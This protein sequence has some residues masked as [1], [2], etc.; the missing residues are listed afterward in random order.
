MALNSYFNRVILR[1]RRHYQRNIWHQRRRIMNRIYWSVTVNNADIL[2]R[3]AQLPPQLSNDSFINQLF[4]GIN[5][6]KYECS[7]LDIIIY[8][9]TIF[10]HYMLIFVD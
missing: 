4:N 5:M 10:N 3:I 7:S 6:S 2:S 9:T 1:R 8:F